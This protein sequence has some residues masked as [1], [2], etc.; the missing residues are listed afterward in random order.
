MR[1][2]TTVQLHNH[3]ELLV[4]AP[5]KAQREKEKTLRYGEL[6]VILPWSDKNVSHGEEEG[7]G[8]QPLWPVIHTLLTKDNTSNSAQLRS[9]LQALLLHYPLSVASQFSFCALTNVIDNVL[10]EEERKTFFRDVLPWM[11]QITCNAPNVFRDK[12][13]PLLRQGQNRKVVFSHEEVVAL[14]CCCFFSLFPGRSFR[15][16]TLTRGGRRSASQQFQLGISS[17]LPPCN[18]DFLFSCSSA[19]DRGESLLGK[20]RCLLEF[21]FQSFRTAGRPLQ[22]CVEFSRV[23]YARFPDFG[24]SDT[25]L[26]PV[27]FFVNGVIEKDKGALQVDF[28]NKIIGGGVLGR[29]C[30]Q[31]EIRFV[32]SPE[33]L[34]SRIIC[35]NLEDCDALFMS[36]AAQMSA[37]TGY[38]NSFRFAGPLDN[39]ANEPLVKGPLPIPNSKAKYPMRDVCVVA[40]D[41]INV[42]GGPDWQYSPVYVER[43]LNKAFVCFFGVSRRMASLSSIH[44]GPIATGN[45]GCG[46]F[47]GDVRLKLLIQWCAASEAGRPLH[48]YP[49]E[50]VQLPEEFRPVQQQL[51]REQWTVSDLYK[52]LIVYNM[53]FADTISKMEAN[54]D[55]ELRDVFQFVMSVP[56]AKLRQKTFERGVKG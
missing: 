40:M 37:Y 4:P 16:N 14:Q 48:Y 6:A 17:H 8:N 41:A 19:F 5:T 42:A 34:L 33:L 50:Q 21:F 51:S 18:Y 3:K 45:W 13:V 31:E 53:Y 47:G 10:S 44:S 15:S 29:G 46:A 36:G 52:A 32:I 28:A 24:T 1:A 12:S 20:V 30:V 43:E 26:Q 56:I 9:L 39:S 55:L 35:E 22:P 11:R 38:A 23:S 49:F 54:R 25:P 27:D 7:G 2:A